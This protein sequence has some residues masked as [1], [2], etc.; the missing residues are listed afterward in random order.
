MTYSTEGRW[1][2][3]HVKGQLWHCWLGH[4][5]CKIVC[6]KT[7]NVSSGTLNST[8]PYRTLLFQLWSKPADATHGLV[9]GNWRYFHVGRYLR[10]QSSPG[11]ESAVYADVSPGTDVSVHRLNLCC[12]SACES[13]LSL[14]RSLRV[15]ST[16]SQWSNYRKKM[17]GRRRPKAKE[18]G[19]R[20]RSWCNMGMGYPLPT[21]G[22]TYGESGNF[23][24]FLITKW[25]GLMRFRSLTWLTNHRHCTYVSILYCF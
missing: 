12:W 25:R 21:G 5:T 18:W 14:W 22:G 16:C 9:A 20:H 1:L 13:T 17:S 23:F 24:R 8:I 11:A 3:N 15:T 4:L 19:L 2:V 10:C 7:Y 6:E